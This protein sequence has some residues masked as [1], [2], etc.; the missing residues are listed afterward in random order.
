MNTEINFLEAHSS[1][2]TRILKLSF[3]FIFLLLA[4]AGLLFFQHTKSHDQLE[5]QSAKLTQLEN[6]LARHQD[7]TLE[8]RKVK[9]IAEHVTYIQGSSNHAVD[10]Y[11]NIIGL[12]S[13]SKK[14]VSYEV[15][16]SNLIIVEAQFNSLEEIAEYISVLLKQPFINDT[17]LTS[18][19]LDE[20]VYQA[21]LTV[22]LQS[23]TGVKETSDY[24]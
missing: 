14:L 16:E 2:N 17:K 21:A 15:L 19:T 13:D 18:V 11:K 22:S 6:V 12:L 9:E 24:E 20:S 7:S 3:I 23:E 8:T 4:I 5:L 10:T 1:K